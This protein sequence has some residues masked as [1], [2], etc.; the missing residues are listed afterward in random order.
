MPINASHRIFVAEYVAAVNARDAERFRRLV[1]PEIAALCVTDANRDFY[2]DWVARAFRHTLPDTYRLDAACATLPPNAP[3]VVP[4][5]MAVDPAPAHASDPDRRAVPAPYQFVVIILQVTQSAGAWRQ[6]MPCPTA[7][8]LAAFAP[9]SSEGRRP[10]R[11]R[12]GPR[13]GASGA[14]A[15]GD[16]GARSRRGR[17]STPCK[18]YRTASG[19]DLTTA[20]GVVEVLKPGVR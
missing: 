2:D 5:G 10:G 14:L 3:P 16:R 7:E 20:T 11:A 18:H 1:H 8:G 15:R 9:R 13:R 12:E 6:V 4:P 19:E 17:S